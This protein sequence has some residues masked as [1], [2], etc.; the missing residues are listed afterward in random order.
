MELLGLTVMKD[1]QNRGIGRALV[2]HCVEFAR[3]K[4]HKAIDVH[5]YADNKRMLRLVIGQDFIPVE[6]KYRARAD[7][8]DMVRLKRYL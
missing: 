3:K 5:V 4:G 8:G 1:S 6:I 2:E 7:G